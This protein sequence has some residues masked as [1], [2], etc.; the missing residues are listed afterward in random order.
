MTEYGEVNMKEEKINK[1]S[2]MFSW[3]KNGDFTIFE[4]NHLF[5]DYED[6]LKKIFS[7]EQIRVLKEIFGEIAWQFEWHNQEASEPHRKNI[8]PKIEKL[9]GQFRN[10]RHRKEG[11]YN[12]KPEW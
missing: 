11:S 2:D 5:D 6:V 12:S 8:V 9:E 3:M 7:P 4:V 1:K 10:H